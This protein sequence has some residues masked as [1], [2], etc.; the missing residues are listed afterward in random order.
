MRSRPRRG[1]FGGCGGGGG[2]GRRRWRRR[3]RPLH[4]DS[5]PDP[6]RDPRPR[7]RRAGP[8]RPASCWRCCS[9]GSGRRHENF[10]SARQQLRARGPPAAPRS[11]SAAS[12]SPPPRR[13]RTTRHLRRTSVKPAAARLFT[14]IQAA[15][16]AGDRA[17]LRQLVAPDL[18]VEWERR[19]DD[20]ERRG[21]RNRV[22]PLGDPQRR[23][24]RPDQ[25]RRRRRTI[26]S[27]SGSR[28]SFATTSSTAPGNH[29]KR[30]GPLG[31]T[32]PPA[33]VLDARAD[34]AA[35]GSSLSI[36]QGAEGAH[37]LDEQ[38]V[39]TPWSDEQAMRDEALVEGAV[40]DAVP[41]GRASRRGRRPRVRGRRARRRARPEPR[42]RP[43][44]SR[45][46]R[47]RGP[48][49]GRGVG[50]GRRRRRRSAARDRPPR[51]RPGAAAPRR[52]ERGGRGWS[53]AARGSSRSGSPRS[54]LPRRR[55]R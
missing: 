1:G 42:R 14:Q 48:A 25:P 50:R 37:A 39:A 49:R 20:F 54:T 41:D 33:R 4:P 5:D 36:E 52:P 43:L 11:A 17:R 27:S 45:R 26:G 13:P 3:R 38:I 21:W 51:G 19:L 28:P 53:S 8:D 10:W 7:P 18:L 16:D 24:R 55:R 47:G 34:A 40:A 29:I 31:E 9:R 6:D 22:Q 23:V 15:W 46:A 30:A 2:G 44:R 32:V 35:A 12:S